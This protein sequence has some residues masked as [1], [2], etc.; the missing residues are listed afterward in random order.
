MNFEFFIS[1]RINR[2]LFNENNVSSRIIKI[3]ITAIALGVI[4]ILI[5]ISTGFGLQKEIKKML[6]NLNGELKIS[7]YENNNSYI[8]IK[9]I[10][11]LKINK[12]KWFDKKKN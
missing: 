8:S 1:K 11:L 5:S 4:I 12:E 6:T 9:P 10:N 7:F 3:A 2:A